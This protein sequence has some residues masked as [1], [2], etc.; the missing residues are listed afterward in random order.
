M[1]HQLK[2]E[3]VPLAEVV[4]AGIVA[5]ADPHRP[6]VLIV[7]DEEI[8][9]D[10]RAAIFDSWGYA[11]M[12][13]YTAEAALEL[14][15]VIPPELLISDVMLTGMNGI[16]LAVIVQRIAP[17]CKILLFSGLP[18][19]SEIIVSARKAGHEFPLLEKPM[20]PAQLQIQLTE[21]NLMPNVRSA[22][23]V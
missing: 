13:A 12:T 16:D 2:I 6:V 19:N 11:T 5:D 21:M 17:D 15:E 1:N 7:D 14:V 8:V 18:A 23:A 4:R 3:V 22:V 10:T 20:R 9:A